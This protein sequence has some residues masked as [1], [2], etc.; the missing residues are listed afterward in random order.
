MS[1]LPSIPK[2]S[3]LA[4]YLLWK[5]VADRLLATL[6][7][8]PGLP[9]IIGLVL[10]VRATSRGPGIFRQSRV[11]KHGRVFTLYKIRSMRLDAETKAS[12]PVWAQ[13]GDSR[14]TPLGRW[15]RSTHLDELP[16]L[17]NVLK[18][19]MSL[20][21]PRPERPEFVEILKEKIPFYQSRL[22]VLPG[23][24]GLAQLN[25][26]PD[27]DLDSVRKKLSF[28]RVYI[29]DL[30]FSL[31]VRLLLATLLLLCGIKPE[32]P[33]SW[34]RLNYPTYS[35]VDTSEQEQSSAPVADGKHESREEYTLPG[36]PKLLETSINAG[37]R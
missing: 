5:Q 30:G 4:S 22:E 21:G 29:A 19:E 12:G 32:K 16:Q 18:G 33:A 3:P 28:D 34:L 14:A 37:S 20:V 31:D 2:A 35:R 6:L 7:L 24:T 10:L 8:L 11:G 15:L 23:I 27:S 17:F 36:D 26:P 13:R 9:L 1:F 25:L